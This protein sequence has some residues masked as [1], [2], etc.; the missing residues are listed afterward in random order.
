M[1][2]FQICVSFVHLFFDLIL[3]V[4]KKKKRKNLIEIEKQEFSLVRG[5]KMN[6]QF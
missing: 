3:K 4:K 5:R 2:S 1:F 6:K